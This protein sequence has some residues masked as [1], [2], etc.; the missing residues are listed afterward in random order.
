VPRLSF[1]EKFLRTQLAR[2]KLVAFLRHLREQRLPLAPIPQMYGFLVESQHSLI[3]HFDLSN[4][5]SHSHDHMAT[6]DQ[7]FPKHQGSQSLRDK[8]DGDNINASE[9]E[10]TS[11]PPSTKAVDSQTL[12][13]P[14]NTATNVT[15][16]RFYLVRSKKN[17]QRFLVR[18]IEFFRDA[19]EKFFDASA[20]NSR[21]Y[22]T[23]MLVAIILHSL[24]DT[25]EE[26]DKLT[27]KFLP[28]DLLDLVGG[29]LIQNKVRGFNKRILCQKPSEYILY[30]EGGIF[31]F[32]HKF[33]TTQFDVRIVK[34]GISK[35]LILAEGEDRT[36]DFKYLISQFILDDGTTNEGFDLSDRFS[37]QPT[38]IVTNSKDATNTEPSVIT[39]PAQD[40][41]Q[42]TKTEDVD[43]GNAPSTNTEA[44]RG[45]I[46]WATI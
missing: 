43:Q 28:K 37:I 33:D 40:E 9:A 19:E 6:P 30:E 27:L 22:A 1:R 25:I 29:N 21:T 23:R 16:K 31:E 42:P 2:Q 26:L 24:R 13:K 35:D 3:G 5:H 8:L 4:V 14:P 12:P 41:S 34:G 39:S 44:S 20:P 32:T 11:T 15:L 46:H 7:K 10:R 38:E 17:P 36:K 18:R 45:D